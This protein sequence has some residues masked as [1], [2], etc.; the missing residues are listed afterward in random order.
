MADAMV[1]LR[2]AADAVGLPVWERKQGVY[3]VLVGRCPVIYL[4][5][6]AHGP[7][8]KDVLQAFFEAPPTLDTVKGEVVIH[9]AQFMVLEVQTSMVAGKWVDVVGAGPAYAGGPNP[10]NMGPGYVWQVDTLWSQFQASGGYHHT[11]DHEDLGDPDRLCTVY[12]K[13]EPVAAWV[14]SVGREGL[15]DLMCHYGGSLCLELVC[16]YDIPTR[17]YV[18]LKFSGLDLVLRPRGPWEVPVWPTGQ[19][20]S[21]EA[22][23][24]A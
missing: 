9:Q 16:R 13:R 11:Q 19:E 24:D 8:S 15:W 7:V 21:G 1:E 12:R 22:V 6:P 18:G 5:R 23:G 20:P 17:G 2:A 10:P 14:L 3:P 4:D